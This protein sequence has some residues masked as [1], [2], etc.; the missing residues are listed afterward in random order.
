MMKLGLSAPT[1][2]TKPEHTFE[3]ILIG[4]NNSS[5]SLY[6]SSWFPRVLS[7]WH[8]SPSS[9]SAP[10]QPTLEEKK[11]RLMRGKASVSVEC[12]PTSQ[13]ADWLIDDVAADL[14]RRLFRWSDNQR[15]PSDAA[16]VIK[17]CTLTN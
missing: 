3:L 2:K 17:W 10:F 5:S 11:K 6:F 15:G 7:R 12:G 13:Y 8:R 1:V 4:R 14:H 9:L 16:V